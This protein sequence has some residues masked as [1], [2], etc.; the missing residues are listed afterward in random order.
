LITTAA[1][2]NA[3][4]AQTNIWRPHGSLEREY[5]SWQNFCC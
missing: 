4:T 1:N 3:L 5:P 2:Q